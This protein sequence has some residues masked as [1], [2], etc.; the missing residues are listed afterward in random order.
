MIIVFWAFAYL[1]ALSAGIM[2]VL[3][4]QHFGLY[5]YVGREN[6]DNYITA[7][8]RAAVFPAIAAAPVLTVLSVV[9][10]FHRPAF[11]SRSEAVSC[12]ALNL[13][14][15]ISTIVWQGRCVWLRPNRKLLNRPKWAL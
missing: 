7:N 2:L 11:F 10:V 8:N 13:I 4:I 1:S 3:Q 15:L 14:N 12:V 9:L 6:F 5:Q